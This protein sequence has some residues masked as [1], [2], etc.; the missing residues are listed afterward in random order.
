MTTMTADSTQPDAASG[1]KANELGSLDTVREEVEQ[2]WIPLDE[3]TLKVD[4]GFGSASFTG[5]IT[6]ESAGWNGLGV[7]SVIAAHSGRAET[8]L[9]LTLSLLD[10]HTGNFE[11][12]GSSE[13]AGGFE[14]ISMFPVRFEADSGFLNTQGQ[15]RFRISLAHSDDAAP[16]LGLDCAIKALSV[17]LVDSNTRKRG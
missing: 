3:I 1:L 9:S 11:V 10:L 16:P 8:R 7:V 6:L 15:L 4:S 17:R 2:S 14:R 12:A 13:I 5:T